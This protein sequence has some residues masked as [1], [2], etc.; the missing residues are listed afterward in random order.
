[1]TAEGKSKIHQDFFIPPEYLKSQLFVVRSYLPGD[2]NLCTEA[3]NSSYDHLFPF[4]NWARPYTSISEAEKKA[5]NFRARYLTNQDYALA[6]LDSDEK[7]WLGSSGYH[8]RGR[9]LE[10]LSAEIGMWIRKD[11][12][13]QGLGT[14]LLC[15]LLGWGFTVWPWERLVWHCNER[16]IASRRTAEKAGM[17]L[18]GRLRGQYRQPDGSR[19]DL[20]SFSA[21]RM[22]WQD[23]RS[24]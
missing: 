7:V 1:M 17:V 15:D 4:L 6:V 23:P 10:N 19:D 5:R 22:E 21:L 9:G 2:G 12:A 11:A 24:T 3:L 8:L 14:H 18:E 20:L 16:N 13:G